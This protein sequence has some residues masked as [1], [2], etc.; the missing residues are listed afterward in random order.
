MIFEV[1]GR[2]TATENNILKGLKHCALKETTQVAI[3]DYPNGGFDQK[4]LMKAI[5]RYKGLE[6]LHDS[7]YLKFQKIIC[8][9]NETIM[10]EINL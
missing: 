5:S 3:L 1:A 7:Q 4:I 9:Q 8:V 10:F 2:E 6:K